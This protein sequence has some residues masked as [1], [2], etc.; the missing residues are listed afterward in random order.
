MIHSRRLPLACDVAGLQADLDAVA[1]SQWHAH[2][3]TGYYDGDWSGVPLS[4]IHI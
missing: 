3:N 4:L 1:P 2:F